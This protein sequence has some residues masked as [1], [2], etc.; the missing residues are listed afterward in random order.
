MHL[1]TVKFLQEFHDMIEVRL[2]ISALVLIMF[3]SVM[4]A[5]S[6]AE[7]IV[8]P[9]AMGNITFPHKAHQE[10]MNDC[11]ICH[12]KVSGK[13][14]GLRIDWGH[15]I[16]KDCHVKINNGITECISCHKRDDPYA[17]INGK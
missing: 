2:L 12:V 9:N 8:L 17:A 6:G 10:R 7:I 4:F 11:T 13:M 14:D 16:C 3:P 1:Y 5:S 15:N